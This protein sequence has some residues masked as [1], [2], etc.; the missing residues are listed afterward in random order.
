MKFKLR[1]FFKDISLT[2]ITE[3]IVLVAFFFIY[4]LIAKNFGPE[5]V[6]EYTLIKRVIAFLYP[7]LLLG[8]GIGLP[9]YIAMSQNKEQRSSYMKAGG[10]IVAVFTFIFLIFINLFK[11]FFAE[12]FFGTTNYTNLVSPFSLFLAGLI[13]H[14]LVYSYFRGRLFVKTF[15]FLQITN[16]ALVPLIILIFFKDITIEKLITLIGTIT[17]I[18]AFTFSLFFIKEFFIW[19][20]KKKL[21]ESFK[22]LIHYSLPRL[23]GDFALAGL[24]SLGP[25]FAAHFASI[26]EVGYLSVS[27]SLLNTIGGVIAPLGIILLPKVS[28]LMTNGKQEIIKE[29]LNFLIVAVGQCSIFLCVQLIIFADVVIKYWLGSEFLNAVPIMRI[30]FSSIFF[31]VFYVAV[32]SVLDAAKI[33]PLNTI[34]LFISLGVFLVIGAILLLLVKFISPII[35]LSIASTSGFICL[36]F[37]SYFSIRK[38]YSENIKEDIHP[39]GVALIINILLGGL[40]ILLK[41]FIVL[42]LYYLISFI[43]G[44][45]LIYFLILWLLKMKWIRQIPEIIGLKD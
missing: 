27:Q 36:G 28:N 45:G 1:P 32:R 3:T 24:L 44:I 2:F 4:R 31:Y 26:Q 8:L 5:G 10:L 41:P 38:I 6:G 11:D 37:L 23:P 42:K 33:K 19:I 16:L 21:K 40:A 14:S 35:S 43:V 15:N 18:I 17:F 25:I 34:N 9:R 22:E 29:N 30:I 13:L 7:V 20:E 39:L 12:I